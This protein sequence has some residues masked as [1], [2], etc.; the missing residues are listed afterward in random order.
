VFDKEF[1]KS[2]NL[3]VSLRDVRTSHPDFSGSSPPVV[4]GLAYHEPKN[5]EMIDMKQGTKSTKFDPSLVDKLPLK[6][7]LL[8]SQRA[9]TENEL[10]QTIMN[11]PNDDT[12]VDEILSR[13][14]NTRLNDLEIL[15]EGDFKE[16]YQEVMGSSLKGAFMNRFK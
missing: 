5:Y 16:E 1:S 2:P 8:E 12:K 10:V 3:D 14:V 13:W 9:N 6:T 11:H 4:D 15:L 7:T